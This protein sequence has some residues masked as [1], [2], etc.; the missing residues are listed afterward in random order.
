VRFPQEPISRSRR[1]L[2][3]ARIAWL[4]G[5]AS[6]ALTMGQAFDLAVKAHPELS[7]CFAVPARS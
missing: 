4:E 2:E 5:G 7:R 3:R 6:P 1:D